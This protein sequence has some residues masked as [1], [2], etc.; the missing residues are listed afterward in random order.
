[1]WL[2]A[3]PE[4]NTLASKMKEGDAR[5]FEAM[6]ALYKKSVYAL[7]FRFTKNALDAE[8][9]TQEVFLQVYRKI[10]SFRGESAFGS[11]L[12]RVTT[13]LVMMHLRKQHVKKESSL[14]LL[15]PDDDLLNDML[16]LGSSNRC[17]PVKH[18]ALVRAVSGLSKRRRALVFL[19]DFKGFTHAEVAQSLG[20][21]IKSSR[22]GISRA[23]QTLRNVLGDMQVH[24]LQ[25][26]NSCYCAKTYPLQTAREI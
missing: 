24:N 13:N 17:D 10:G 19:R 8:D 21:T 1:M 14:D 26:D 22:S 5:A 7:C 20:I 4:A 25:G 2:K 23:H 18:I 15:S 6:Y 16:H 11:W 3:F 12:Y 9:L